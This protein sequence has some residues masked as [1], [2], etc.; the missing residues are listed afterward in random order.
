MRVDERRHIYVK[1]EWYQLVWECG[2][3]VVRDVMDFT[4]ICANRP[5]ESVSAKRTNIENGFLSIN[6]FKTES[7]GV[8]VKRLP[9][10]GRLKEFITRQQSRVITNPIYLP[11]IRR[12]RS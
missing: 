5:E 7:S 9:V 3:Q 4:Y 1:D 2:D 10:E 11:T 6:L 8:R 12:E